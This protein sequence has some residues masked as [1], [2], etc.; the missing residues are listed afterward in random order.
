MISSKA[1]C[2]LCALSVIWLALEGPVGLPQSEGNSNAAPGCR[3]AFGLEATR[4]FADLQPHQ[5]LDLRVAVAA[6]TVRKLTVVQEAGSVHV[7]VPGP[8]G[9]A[10][11]YSNAAGLHSTLRVLVGSQGAA[12]RSLTIDNFT[13]HAAR[14]AVEVAAAQPADAQTAREQEAEG[15]LAEAEGLGRIKGSAPAAILADYD[16][17][18][19]DWRGLGDSAEVARALTW[20]AVD[21]FV[22]GEAAEGLPVIEQA[23]SLAASM[24][25]V[26]A[27]NCWKAAGYLN[28]QLSHYDAAREAYARALAAYRQTGDIFNQE[29]LLENLSSVERMQ[30]NKGDA[31]HDAAAAELLAEQIHDARGELGIAEQLGS[32]YATSG[33]LEQAWKTYSQAVSL[34]Q[35]NPD[36]R[37]EGYV[38]SDLGVVYTDLGDFAR[39]E[40]ALDHAA[41]VWAG[42][43]DPYGQINTLDDTGDLLLAEGKPGQARPFYDRG[44]ALAAKARSDHY[45]IFLLRG[46]GD[47]YLVQKDAAAAERNDREALALAVQAKEGDSIAYLHCALG[48][49]ALLERDAGTAGQPFELC[50]EEARAG[51]S[52][53]LEIRAEGGLARV[54]YN[55]GQLD[56]AQADCEKALAVIE[57]Q[58]GTLRSAD[59]RTSYFAS[60]HSYYDL[61]IQILARLDRMHPGQGYPW[62]AFLVAER[63]RAR[64]LLDQVAASDPGQ[65]ADPASALEAQY[66]DVLRQL[67]LLEV[68]DGR[69]GA[70]A[71]RDGDAVA[72]LTQEE[73]TLQAE[74]DAEAKL[75][76]AGRAIAP[77]TLQDIQNALPRSHAALLEYWAGNDASYVWCIGSGGVRMLRLPRAAELDK[78]VSGFRQAILAETSLGANVSAQ[79]RAVLI[80]AARQRTR[81]LAGQLARILVPPGLL[82]ARTSTLLVVGDGPILSVP[83]AALPLASSPGIRMAMLS[84]P[85]AAILSFLEARPLESRPTRIAVF[86]DSAASPTAGRNGLAALPYASGEA[87]AIR[88]LFGAS[89]TSVFSGS[90][91]TPSAIRD[92]DWS[93]YNIGHFAMHAILNGHFAELNGLVTSAGGAGAQNSQ[94]L[95]YGDVCRLHARLDLVVLSA[96]DTA[97]GQNVAGEGLLGL[98]HAFF[99]AGS[100]RVLGT[101]W[102]VDDQATSEWMRQFYLALRTS[103]S[104]AQA[105]GLAQRRMAANPQWSAIYYWGGFTLAGDW[106]PLP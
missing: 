47:S 99:A 97:L 80:P 66:D 8:A 25:P 59:L 106:R 15:A 91:A 42:I 12:D 82:P 57:E 65:V 76:P 10:A 75:N 74:V 60:M 102:P 93:P 37:M 96:C 22:S 61:D 95:W 24:P 58:R 5:K 67:R 78:E 46:I 36:P 69:R 29:V 68:A 63:S 11:V 71:G 1:T 104:P 51:E 81:L 3:T 54:A 40:D 28:A 27:A 85:S 55:Q 88:G 16:R 17:A 64:T 30:G 100:Q 20:K 56:D 86:T 18:I 21:L 52:P 43:S 44:L 87:A 92:L 90:A 48:D 38:W 50:D 32:I 39:A 101:L 34:L 35:T 2:C 7:V 26:E 70:R 83:F 94:M 41:S 73:H 14:V 84:E 23:T 6:G 9:A 77:L 72:R 89:A 79:Q 53:L 45:R 4:C 105:L 103:R 62:K 33:N 13:A 31:L 49:A 98:T 19:A